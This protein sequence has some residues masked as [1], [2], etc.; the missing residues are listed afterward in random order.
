MFELK[1]IF[2]CLSGTSKRH[3]RSSMPSSEPTYQLCRS[4][5][6][7]AETNDAV[8]KPSQ[9]ASQASSSES[10]GGPGNSQTWTLHRLLKQPPVQCHL[11]LVSTMEELLSGISLEQNPIIC[12]HDSI[13]WQGVWHGAACNVKFLRV[14]SLTPELLAGIDLLITQSHPF[15]LQYY[16]ARAVHVPD[17][18]R[19]RVVDGPA[20]RPNSDEV[21]ADDRSIGI[22]SILGSTF[23]GANADQYS[24]FYQPETVEAVLE[25]LQP[26]PEDFI[27]ALVNE[28]CILGNVQRAISRRYFEHSVQFG[29]HAA[30]RTAREIALGLMHLHLRGAAHGNLRPSQILLVESHADHRGFIAKIADAGLGSRHSLCQTP[31]ATAHTAASGD[32]A[33]SGSL[34]LN[35]PLSYYKAPELLQ[36]G[37]GVR[38]EGVLPLTIAEL[39]AADVYSFGCILYEILNG[40][41]I[42]HGRLSRDQKLPMAT[43][44]A[45]KETLRTVDFP[46]L[47]VESCA[48]ASGCDPQL[49]LLCCCCLST[50]PQ[51]R[52]GLGA[53]LAELNAI[54]VKMRTAA[55]AARSVSKGCCGGADEDPQRQLSFSSL[56]VHGAPASV[57]LAPVSSLHRN[58][59]NSDSCNF[60]REPIASQSRPKTEL[61]TDWGEQRHLDPEQPLRPL[62]GY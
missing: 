29:A 53:V 13:V 8:N 32:E 54:D 46:R 40:V 43:G 58:S 1:N 21:N 59:S 5:R 3:E 44:K 50:H 16:L 45:L 20:L 38:G 49:Q 10:V 34:Q 19:W 4:S 31:R 55:R 61:V 6:F 47:D 26:K 27:I 30:L 42:S 60:N 36:A 62:C 39:Q 33:A 52:P 12:G 24:S 41:P 2:S 51:H 17:G 35:R 9:I 15:I 48:W 11:K 22:E 56:H 7:G 14:S 18:S 23:F 37:Y 25:I 57:S 28:Y